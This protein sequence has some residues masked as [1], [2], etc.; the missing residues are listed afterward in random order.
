MLNL[1]ELSSPSSVTELA[2][3]ASHQVPPS[4]VERFRVGY[5]TQERR[6]KT[7]WTVCVL[8]L[9]GGAPLVFVGMAARN[10]RL[11]REDDP[12]QGRR[13]A[14]GRAVADLMAYARVVLDYR[15]SDSVTLEPSGP[16]NFTEIGRK[17]LPTVDEMVGILK[18][19]KKGSLVSWNAKGCVCWAVVMCFCFGHS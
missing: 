18:K 6:G 16:L 4:W 9:T 19:K 17:K 8:A 12:E 7:R 15:G 3:L 2:I 14:F 10:L 11:D 5:Q 1:N 13:Y